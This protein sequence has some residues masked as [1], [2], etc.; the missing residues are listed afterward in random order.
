MG[1]VIASQTAAVQA[2]IRDSYAER[3]ERWSENGS[4]YELPCAVKLGSALVGSR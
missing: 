2:R 4:G 3:L 1:A